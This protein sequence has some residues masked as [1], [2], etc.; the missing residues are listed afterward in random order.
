[1]CALLTAAFGTYGEVVSVSLRKKGGEFDTKNWALVTFAEPEAAGRALYS[2]VSAHSRCCY[3]VAVPSRNLPSVVLCRGEQTVVVDEAF[4]EVTLKVKPAAIDEKLGGK[5]ALGSI[6]K[7]QNERVRKVEA[8]NTRLEREEQ[9]EEQRSAARKKRLEK[10]KLVADPEAD[11]KL[12]SLRKK[13]GEA[14]GDSP[15]HKPSGPGGPR[16]AHEQR[17][18]RNSAMDGSFRE[19]KKSR[20]KK[21]AAVNLERRT[22]NTTG[23]RRRSG[24]TGRDSSADE[25]DI[26]RT[27]MW[28]TAWVGGIPAEFVKNNAEMKVLRLFKKF[29]KVVRVTVRKKKNDGS[30]YKSWAFIT[31][32]DAGSVASAMK[33]EVRIA[34]YKC[35][36]QVEPAAVSTELEKNEEGALK[37]MWEEQQ[38]KVRLAYHQHSIRGPVPS[39]HSSVDS[40]Q[41]C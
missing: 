25:V 23:Q 4:D 8:R 3:S 13:F 28:C 9:L 1:M 14:T 41:E 16:T 15:S 6:A 39:A 20:K 26:D 11:E 31:F 32:Q 5:G 2:E 24:G 27:T 40:S 17:A 22:I 38:N 7:Q 34:D 19:R 33:N 21:K 10:K 12:A 29:G 18:R 36:L 37:R 30:T 35:V